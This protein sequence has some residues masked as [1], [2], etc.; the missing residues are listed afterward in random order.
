VYG[1]EVLAIDIF[2]TLKS[3]FLN[4]I[5]RSYR[6]SRANTRERTGRYLLARVVFAL[7]DSCRGNG[8]AV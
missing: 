7:V 4:V 3:H 5:S 6:I 8:E 1:A 2:G